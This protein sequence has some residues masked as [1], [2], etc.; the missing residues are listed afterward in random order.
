MKINPQYVEID[1]KQ[2]V[3]L[4][5][6]EF[7]RLAIKAD[8]WM[9]ALP[10]PNERGNYPLEA[11]AIVTA[12]DIIQTRRTLGLTQA[13]LAR[14]AG[15]RQTTIDRIEHGRLGPVDILDDEH[16]LP[17][18]RERLEVALERANEI[19]LVHLGHRAEDLLDRPERESLAIWRAARPEDQRAAQSGREFV[20]QPTLADAGRTDGVDEVRTA[21]RSSLHPERRE[22]FELALSTDELR[23]RQPEAAT[24][25]HG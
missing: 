22:G 13:D 18:L 7:E 25:W 24:G 19:R 11:L 14:R 2:M 6:K 9:P 3:V 4:P 10:E 15:I 8:V 1:G 21:G 20:D 5:A 12:R 23:A 17:I 16:D